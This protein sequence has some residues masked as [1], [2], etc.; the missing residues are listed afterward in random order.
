MNAHSVI[1]KQAVRLLVAGAI[2]VAG[3]V[4]YAGPG[5]GSPARR[6]R[7]TEYPLSIIYFS[8]QPARPRA[9]RDFVAGMGIVNDETGLTV[10]HG[11]INCPARIGGRGV[12][13]VAKLF[14]SGIAVCQ[15]VVP[16]RSGGKR[17]RATI[18]VTSDEGNASRSFTRTIRP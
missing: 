8:T 6:D 4:S 18:K 5:A 15:W 7:A 17:F 13:M 9:G 14:D 16:T 12:R 10:D 11:Q 3:V 1:K 2:V